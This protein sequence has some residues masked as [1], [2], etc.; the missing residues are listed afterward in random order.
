MP[1]P[2]SD[3]GHGTSTALAERPHAPVSLA[4]PPA[5]DARR[6]IE[7]IAADRLQVFEA[8]IDPRTGK[9]LD[10]PYA[11]NKSLSEH[12]AADYHGRCLIELIQNGNDAHPPERHDG[13]IEVLLA[14]E[15]RFGTVYV[16]N[17]GLPFSPK[18]VDALSKIGKSSKPPG[19]AIGNKGL[20]FRSVSHVC[21]APEIYSQC[22]PALAKPAFDGFCFTLEHGGALDGYFENPRVGQLAEADL[23][24]FSIPRWLTEQPRKVRAFAERGFAS[25]VRLS[26]RDEEAHADALGQCRMLMKQSA[27]TLLF[28]ERLSRLTAI[29]E[30]ADAASTDRIVLTRCETP[31]PGSP[32]EA[33]IIDLGRQGTFLLTKARVPEK[34]MLA[35]IVA[36]VATKQLHGSWKE[37]SGDGQVA[38]AVRMD[39]GPVAPRLY[40]FLPMSEGAAAPF[41]G[42]LHGSFFPTSSRK[43][44]DSSVELNRL[45][46]EEAAFLAAATVRWLAGNTST[47]RRQDV[48][49]AGTA[50]RAAVDLLVWGKVSSL[51]GDADDQTAHEQDGRIDLPATVAQRVAD[52]SGE[53]T[54]TAIVPCLDAPQDAAH[55]IERIAWCPPR[56]ARFWV[57]ASETFTVACLADHGRSLGIA[58][59]W[60]GLGEERA[61]RLVGFLKTHAQHEF[62]ENPTPSER[63]KIAE[64]IARSLPRG[65]KMPVA[66]WKAFYRDLVKFMDESPLPLAGHQIIL[67]GDGTLRSVRSLEAVKEDTVVRPRRRRRRGGKV[68]ASLFFPPAPRRT[69]RD[70]DETDDGLKV[71]S[72]LKGYFAFASEVL[73]WHGELKRAREFLEDGLVSA[74]DGE[75]VLT[76]I[77]QVVTN[78]ATINEAVAGLRWAFAIWRR[79]GGRLVGG[80]RNYRLLVPTV[81]GRLVSATDA[82]FSESWPDETLGKRLKR[83]LD[84]APPGIDDIVELS[85]QRLAPTSH[86]AFRKA[87][88]AQWVEFLTA[89]GVN[90]GLFA[91]K[92]NA[93]GWFKAHELTSFTFCDE[94]AIPKATAESWKKDV[95]SF[96]PGGTSLA[97]STD[98]SFKGPLWWLPGQGHHE[99]F[100][101]GCRELY[102]ALVVEWLERAPG[103]VFDV[104]I[105]HRHFASD[106]RQWST[107]VAAF[108]RGGK[109]MPADDPQESGAVRGHFAPCDV[110]IASA[111]GERFPYFLRQPAVG[112]SK[113]IERLGEAG[114]ERLIKRARLRV[115]GERSILIDQARFLAEQFRRRT[116]NRHY[117]AQFANLYSATWKVIA[118]RYASEP[119]AFAEAGAPECLVVRRN[120]ELLALVP[121]TASAANTSTVFVRDN[122]DEIASSLIGAAGDAILEVKGANPAR[123][124]ALFVA[125]YGDCV[126]LFSGLRYD[127]RADNVPINELPRDPTALDVCAW[128]RPMAAFAIEALT[129]TAAG[130]LPTDRSSLLARLGNVGL[131]FAIDVAFELN[132]AVISPAGGRRAY[133]FRRADGTPLVVA[134]HVGPVTWTVIEDC[135]QAICDA[136]DLPQ[137]AANMRLLARELAAAGAA[138]GEKNIEH[139]DLELLGRT[140]Y[141]DEHTLTV[142][143]HL[144]GDQ[145]DA[146]EAWIRAVVHLVGGGDALDTFDRREAGA[147]G[148]PNLLRNALAPLLA[149]AGMSPDTVIDACRRSFT[150]ENFREHLGFTLAAFNKSLIATGSEPE[151]YPE[152]H[153]NQVLDFV[154]EHEVEIIQ[155]LRNTVA[156]K[157]ERLEAAPEYVE[158]RDN[159]RSIAP[160]PAWLLLHKNVPNEVVATHVK[161]WLAKVGAPPLGENPSGLP[162]L[163]AVRKANLVTVAKFAEV[164]SPLVRTWCGLHG[165]KAPEVWSDRDEPDA[166]LRVALEAAGIMD[167]R[168]VDEAGLLSWCAA[169]G[170]W[171]QG[172][173]E[174]LDRVALEI[175]TTDIED[176]EAKAR[177]EAEKREARERSV[178]FDG[179]DV[180]PKTADWTRISNV[181][182]EKLSQRIKGMALGRPADLAAITKRAGDKGRRPPGRPDNGP[183]RIPQ[184]KKD[185]IGRLGELV[186]YHWLK[187][188]FPNQD[189]DAAWVSENGNEQLGRAQGSDDLGFDFRVQYRRQTWQIEVKASVGDQQRFEMGE[190]EVRAAR[191]AARPRSNTRY[192]VVYVANPHDP[193]ST[194]IDV[195]PNPMS[196]EADGVLDLLGE[197]VRFGF[198]RQEEHSS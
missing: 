108:L 99:S 42:Y 164:A 84:A 169:L 25:V 51:D 143:H 59:L 56:A 1:T 122:D 123:V 32:L 135:L 189:I 148:D 82:V 160:D 26:L 129:G 179:L 150:T 13:E 11:Q 170:L 151:T 166:K 64:S 91:I 174:T 185:M 57:D 165:R 139:E 195:L 10:D 76:R 75:T 145:L 43:A 73:P 85:R 15:G 45:L 62:L 20:G 127:V 190:T 196:P 178:E 80:N 87:R 101:N 72:P 7:K 173:K 95:E 74:Y 39:N 167:F 27:P 52:S 16:A 146:G 191:E 157:L 159:I 40:T 105:T 112:L 156:K 48:I 29:V 124:G 17:R 130:Q 68:E 28:M 193:G 33:S 115:L 111:S 49:D 134:Q 175:E 103:T 66:R 36:G 92:K 113:A 96:V 114:R 121:S 22:S 188:R 46:L 19:E 12:V 109:W 172:M 144:L 23:P 83:F 35:A 120:S 18:Q 8:T 2:P 47:E 50:A 58:P 187:E 100:S 162:S 158:L 70:E 184:V 183:R 79:A 37:W 106:T 30:G 126:R 192:V 3:V 61:K 197:G 132:G 94:V 163:Q 104:G 133:L 194:H 34:A 152:L 181:V 137:I 149:S 186:V 125:L 6:F 86:R 60:L 141:L 153:V 44:I 21:E 155:A 180:D 81:Q 78:E 171:P 118:D 77:S 5:D 14:N 38:L 107:P 67:C 9:Y 63:A 128:L 88:T 71:P 89:L 41:H 161:A 90:R 182:A 177:E 97:Y 110:W 55:G 136:I 24:M 131:Q 69:D 65:R 98:Y 4:L 176:A 142:A 168:K 31:F 119:S 117:E 93:N 53:F 198:R 102:A 138:V 116:V 154:M 147:V 140:M 54:D